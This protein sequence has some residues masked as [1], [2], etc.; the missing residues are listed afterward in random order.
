MYEALMC[1]NVPREFFVSETV[2]N[3]TQRVE[4]TD[5]IISDTFFNPIVECISE[6]IEYR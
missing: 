3:G 5:N 6:M 1:F 2:Y 4:R